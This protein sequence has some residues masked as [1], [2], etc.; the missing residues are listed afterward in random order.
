LDTGDILLHENK[1]LSIPEP[2]E[3][4]ALNARVVTQVYVYVED[5]VSAVLV[6]F[7]WFFT[8]QV[9]LENDTTGGVVS[10][11]KGIPDEVEHFFA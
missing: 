1:S 6:V 3:S 10:I 8:F 2:P 9:I 11:R 5:A 7:E 4:I